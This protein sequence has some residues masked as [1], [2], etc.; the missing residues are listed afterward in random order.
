MIWQASKTAAIV[1]VAVKA[2][3]RGADKCGKAAHDHRPRLGVQRVHDQ[4]GEQ[5]RGRCPC[6]LP[7]PSR[8]FATFHASQMI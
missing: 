3:V 6:S 4:T 5:I 7:C 1:A 8:R 2:G